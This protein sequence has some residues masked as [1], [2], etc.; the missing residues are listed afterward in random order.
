MRKYLDLIGLGYLI[1]KIQATFIKKT[2]TIYA[3]NLQVNASAN[4]ITEPEVKSVKINGSSTN[5]AS[6]NNC[7]MQYDTTNQCLKFIFN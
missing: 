3:A 7:V 5:S 2:D 4:Y 1:E 6:S